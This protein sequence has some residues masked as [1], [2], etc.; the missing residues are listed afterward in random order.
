MMTHG[1]PTLSFDAIPL[2]EGVQ[3]TP[4][5]R[6]TLPF[7][8]AAP[9][10]S[11]IRQMTSERVI[12]DI[13]TAYRS[14]DYRF[15]TLPPGASAWA[16]TL[17][18]R[19]VRAV[20]TVVGGGRPTSILE[21]GGGSTWVASKLRQR[22]LPESYVIVDPS[23]RDAAEG[24]EVIRDYFPNAELSNCRFDL[25][26]GFSVLEHVP[27]PLDFLTAIRRHLAPGGRAILIFPD[28]E[29]VL[30][31]GDLN[32]LLHEHL[33]YFTDAS[34][35]WLAAAAGLHVTSLH[36][37]NDTFTLTVDTTPA[38]GD[39]ARPLDE[40]PL[41]RQS[42]T[43]FQHLLTS[44]GTTIR[45]HLDAG[46]P[47]AFHGATQGLNTFCFLTGMGDHPRIHLYDGD[48]AKHNLYLPACSAP[49]RSPADESYAANAL[50]VVS[51]MSFFDQ[52]EQFAVEKAGVD[53][54]RVLPLAGV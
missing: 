26:L 21:I 47:V 44:T 14:D 34:C 32:V 41:L 30:R 22:Y 4:G 17:G 46:E 16:D 39:V 31:R 11:P 36:S 28:C 23:V 25:I 10:D 5:V 53:R 48:S 43:R 54:S 9:L 50:I 15:K 40:S 33:S 3:R 52:I 38:S 24:V 6:Q 13:V 51:A 27:D 37:Q 2:W 18:T 42:A 29:Q 8:L 45:R 7:V 20:E 1:V 49:I 35:R 19:S 12:D